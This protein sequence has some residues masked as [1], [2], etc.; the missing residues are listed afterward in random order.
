[1]III[2]DMKNKLASCTKKSG[3]DF[4]RKKYVD[5]WTSAAQMTKNSSKRVIMIQKPKAIVISITRVVNISIFFGLTNKW[6]T[7]L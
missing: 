6:S 4:N 2:T 1:M 7:N 3:M 5:L